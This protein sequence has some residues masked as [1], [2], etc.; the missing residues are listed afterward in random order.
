MIMMEKFVRPKWVNAYLVQ[1]ETENVK[2]TI[3]TTIP[4][5][6]Q[7]CVFYDTKYL[8]FGQCLLRSSF[9]FDNELCHD[10]NMK[11]IFANVQSNV[12]V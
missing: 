7:D 6:P 8:V 10:K 2:Q 12:F 9:S 5:T 11:Q 1:I 3:L 4:S